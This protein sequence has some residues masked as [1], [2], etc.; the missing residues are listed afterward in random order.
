MF[1]F[2]LVPSVPS[3]L[4]P[5]GFVPSVLAPRVLVHPTL[6]RSPLAPCVLVPILVVPHV[7]SVSVPTGFVPGVLD[8][9]VLV[10]P[11]LFLLSSLCFR[12][13]PSGSSCS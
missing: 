10:H 7:H 11:A 3:V 5:C 6:F 12:S 2:L 4:V 8:P 9:S 1:W 13:D